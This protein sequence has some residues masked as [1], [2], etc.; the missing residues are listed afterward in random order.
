MTRRSN[1]EVLFDVL[2][3]LRYHSPAKITHI[4]YKT[5]VNCLVLRNFLESLEKQGYV[6]SQSVKQHYAGRGYNKTVYS[7]TP[8]GTVFHSGLAKTM[9]ELN[10]FYVV[11]ERTR[12]I[13]EAENL[14]KLKN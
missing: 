11:D 3:Y 1:P 8:K 13:A 14:K 5:N 6:T 10:N 2:N 9:A 4:M 7:L 12:Y